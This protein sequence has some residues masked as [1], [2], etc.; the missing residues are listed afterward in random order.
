FFNLRGILPII[1]TTTYDENLYHYTVRLFGFEPT[2]ALERF[3]SPGVVEFFAFFYYSY[4][5]LIASFIFV[6]VFTSR[7]DRRLSHFA[8][9]LLLVVSI[10]QFIYTLVPGFGPYAH[11]AHEYQGPLRGG[12]FYWMVIDTV[13]K[14]GALRDI[15]PSLH[16]ALPMF[17]TF[18]AWKHY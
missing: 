8:T 14:A 18:F 7:S 4:F 17:L 5:F 6:M 3:S 9:G 10:G 11:L 15:F 12:V 16:T 2:V 13:S 1:N